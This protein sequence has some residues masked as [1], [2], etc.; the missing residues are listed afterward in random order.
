M[1]S[2][3]NFPWFHLIFGASI[4]GLIYLV[5]S[6]YTVCKTAKAGKANKYVFG[7]DILPRKGR[8][9]NGEVV[10]KSSKYKRLG[11]I[12][13]SMKDYGILNKRS[14]LIECFSNKDAIMNIINY[15]VLVLKLHGPHIWCD[16]KYKLRKFVG[17]VE[18]S[19]SPNWSSVYEKYKDRVKECVSK[20]NFIQ[21]CD[22]SYT[23]EY[24]YLKN[25]ERWIV[26]ETY[27]EYKKE[28]HYSIHPVNAIY[29]KVK[30]AN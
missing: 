25:A 8:T 24:D 1:D 7:F 2:N 10:T 15:P 18:K 14:I 22:D 13:N 9:S 28:Y 17:Y 11:V 21:S 29:A 16:S 23:K 4:C 26:S 27:D 19:P 3:F 6:E 30:Y 5:F 12:G 20:D